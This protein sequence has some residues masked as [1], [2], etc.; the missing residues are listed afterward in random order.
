V[1]D[2]ILSYYEHQLTYN[3]QRL[4]KQPDGPTDAEPLDNRKL[5]RYTG[6]REVEKQ[7]PTS[8]SSY[9]PAPLVSLP[10]MNSYRVF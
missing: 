10:S 2:P 9:S 5:E 4:E 6:R 8:V 3:L 1:S 7:T